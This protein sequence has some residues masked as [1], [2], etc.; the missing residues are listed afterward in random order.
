MNTDQ[1]KDYPRVPI[2]DLMTFEGRAKHLYT[3][4]PKSGKNEKFTLLESQKY[5]DDIVEEE[6]ERTKREF[7]HAQVRVIINKCRQAGLTTY[8]NV[9]SIDR[10]LYDS[11]SNGIIDR[12]STRLNSSHVAI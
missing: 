12:K 2:S 1:Y 9:R 7:G 4:Q 11:G 5:L 10:Q 3:I 6:Y 8:C